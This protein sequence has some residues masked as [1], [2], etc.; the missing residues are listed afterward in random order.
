VPLVSTDNVA[1]IANKFELLIG[2]D[3]ITPSPYTNTNYIIICKFKFTSV[4]TTNVGIKIPITSQISVNAIGSAVNNDAE[5]WNSA[6]S[7]LPNW[8]SGGIIGI[9]RPNWTLT[10]DSNYIYFYT[11]NST[12][13]AK[14][15]T[16]DTYWIGFMTEATPSGFYRCKIDALTN[17]TANVQ[18]RPYGFG[19]LDVIDKYTYIEV[20]D[21][22]A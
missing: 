21:Y 10:S 20:L 11:S 13:K 18:L 5:I 22:N 7:P 9:G 3:N 4:S 6:T 14:L 15:N 2:Y 16:T 1:L 17:K 19:I 12:E 8:T